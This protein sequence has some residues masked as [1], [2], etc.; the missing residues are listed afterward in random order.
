MKFDE[1]TGE[2]INNDNYQ[3]QDIIASIYD[4]DGNY[5]IIKKDKKVYQQSENGERTEITDS[6][7]LLE[8]LDLFSVKN[9]DVVIDEDIE[10]Y[11]DFSK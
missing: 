5:Y 1:L 2:I 10:P 3:E 11:D 9:K 8:I 6:K 4:R 7:K